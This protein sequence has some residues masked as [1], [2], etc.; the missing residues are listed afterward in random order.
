MGEFFKRGWMEG[1]NCTTQP[2]C[3]DPDHFSGC[4]SKNKKKKRRKNLSGI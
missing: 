4:N 1:E 2:T 3:G